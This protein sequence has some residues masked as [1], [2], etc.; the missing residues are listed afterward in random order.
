M[1][2]K[3]YTLSWQNEE[4]GEYIQTVEYPERLSGNPPCPKCGKK[5]HYWE[6]QIDQDIMGND[7]E[8]W[9]YVCYECHIGTKP[10]EI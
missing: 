2:P 4:D 9:N 10:E 5:T 6:G 7:I 3:K 1:Q 8:G